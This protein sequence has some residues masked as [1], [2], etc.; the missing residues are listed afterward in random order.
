MQ[1]LQKNRIFGQNVRAARIA[2]G[3]T[4]EQ[5]AAKLQLLGLDISRSSYSQIECGMRN[6]HVDEI[7]AL[8]QIFGVSY[9]DFF[10]GLEPQ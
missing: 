3:M 5:T 9:D 4:Q 10:A 2:A 7:A 8:K 6:V 1:I